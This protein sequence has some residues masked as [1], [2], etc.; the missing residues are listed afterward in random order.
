MD[1][2]ENLRR[3]FLNSDDALTEALKLIDDARRTQ[4]G[5]LD[6]ARLPI[7]FL[8][9]QIRD[10]TWL[11]TL[12][13]RFTQVSDLGPLQGLASLTTLDCGSTQ[14]GDLGPL[15][16]LASLTT[17]DC[18][19]TQVSD[20]GPLQGLASL[21][22]LDCSFT[23][24]RDLSPISGLT[25][26][27]ILDCRSTRVVD[28]APLSGLT[29]LTLRIDSN[30]LRLSHWWNKL[31]G[32]FGAL[33]RKLLGRLAIQVS[34]IIITLGRLQVEPLRKGLTWLAAAV[35]LAA[36][37]VE[38]AASLA[39][40]AVVAT[41][42]AGAKVALATAM[43]SY[44]ATP[45]TPASA[46]LVAVATPQGKVAIYRGQ[47]RVGLVRGHG[48]PVVSAAF[49]DNGGALLT[50]DAAGV[51]RVTRLGALPVLDAFDTDPALERLNA[52]LWQRY[53]APVAQAAQGWAGRS[54][55]RVLAIGLALAA[56]GAWVASL[57]A[58]LFAI[59]PARRWLR[60]GPRFRRS[61]R[62]GLVRGE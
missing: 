49:L 36:L 3:S 60:A 30:H 10:L 5:H 24:V 29:R 7:K 1:I 45:T 57:G 37:V 47:A 17:L 33:P 19:S 39:T 61:D 9:P 12:N 38:G 59:L 14:V 18:G 53:S 6:L 46:A 58:R 27:T 23:P 22:T 26:L 8:P 62:L 4:S 43:V 32:R 25:A 2:L 41:P 42:G 31:V 20:L 28:L 56:L 48:A 50:T 54:E 11:T 35:C 13:C 44:A 51:V 34:R 55:L 52:G 15:R 40:S 16:G 21:T